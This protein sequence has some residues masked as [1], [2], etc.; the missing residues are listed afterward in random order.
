MEDANTYDRSELTIFII[1][2]VTLL[3]GVFAQTGAGEAIISA[4][5]QLAAG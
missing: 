1:L 4:I 5:L 3:V 2:G